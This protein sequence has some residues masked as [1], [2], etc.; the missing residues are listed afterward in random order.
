MSSLCDILSTYTVER[1]LEAGVKAGTLPLAA[2]KT[3]AVHGG[4]LVHSLDA[5]DGSLA[6]DDE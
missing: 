5:Q 4:A 6:G 2:E 1:V 3:F